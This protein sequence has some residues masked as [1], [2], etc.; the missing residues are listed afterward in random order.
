MKAAEALIA[1]S[2]TTDSLHDPPAGS[3]AIGPLIQNDC[4]D[5]T[6][7]Y[8]LTGG[9]A[10]VDR[11]KLHG[12]PQQHEVMLDWYRLVFS[13]GLDPYIVH[14][15]FLLIDEYQA[16]IKRHGLGPAKGE[17]GHDPEIPYGRCVPGEAPQIKIFR[18]NGATHFW[19]A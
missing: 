4:P 13:Y 11:R 6:K 16:V 14:R 3:V 8:P 10:Y 17:P 5:W 12:F 1:W 9:A 7:G 18:C 19:P 2:R 15:A